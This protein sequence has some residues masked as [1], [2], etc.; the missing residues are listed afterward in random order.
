[1]FRYI[2]QI[3][4]PKSDRLAGWDTGIQISMEA[5]VVGFMI[6]GKT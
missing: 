5:F 6:E 2:Y 1:M 4:S 3:G